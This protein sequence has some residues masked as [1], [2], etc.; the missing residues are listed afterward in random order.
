MFDHL[1]RHDGVEKPRPLLSV[2]SFLFLLR[3]ELLQS[4]GPVADPPPEVRVAGRVEPSRADAVLHRVDAQHDSPQASQWLQ[5]EGGGEKSQKVMNDLKIP[6]LKQV[7]SLSFPPQ[8]F[9]TS[10]Y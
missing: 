1:R 8:N 3:R 10:I 2:S 4:A 5:E 6:T 7:L 9:F